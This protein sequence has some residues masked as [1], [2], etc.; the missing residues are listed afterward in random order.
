MI[1]KQEIQTTVDGIFY[2]V[3]AGEAIP[4]PLAA[5]WKAANLEAQIK[6]AGMV[7]DEPT[8]TTSKT[9]ATASA[10]TDATSAEQK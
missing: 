10:T 4:P 9:K 5:Y 8:T 3:N 2:K 7:E 6:A 1:A